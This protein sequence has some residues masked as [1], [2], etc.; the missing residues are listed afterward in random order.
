MRTCGP[1]VDVQPVELIGKGIGV[2]VA[3]GRAHVVTA[4]PLPSPSTRI[5]SD[6]VSNEQARLLAAVKLARGHMSEHVCRAHAAHDDDLRGV[7]EAHVLMLDDPHFLAEVARRIERDLLPAELALDDSFRAIATRLNASEDEYLR[8]R[9]EDMRDCCQM[10]LDGLQRGESA[11]DDPQ[12]EGPGAI[13]VSA[14]LH[15]S[16]VLRARRAGAS[17]FVS[18]SRA[19]LSHGAILLRASGIA[20]VGAV[21]FAGAEIANGT[22]L[23]V[24]GERGVVVVNPSAEQCAATSAA[25]APVE[26]VRLDTSLPPI[27][28]ISSD[29]RRVV[30]WANID[31]PADASLCFRH[32]LRGIGL[33]RTEF[34]ALSEG[35]TPGE[36]AQTRVYRQLER[37]LEGR[38]LVVRTFDLGAEKIPLGLREDRGANPALGLRGLRR[39]LHC[40]PR[41]LRV[42]LRALLRATAGAAAEVRVLLPMVTYA[43][44]LR[45]ALD[46]L[47]AA[48]DELERAGIAYNHH[49]RVG[50][51]IEVPAAALAVEEI[52]ALADFV[53]VG[54]NDLSQY[55]SATGRDVASLSHYLAPE[56]SGLYRIIDH[57]MG[58]ARRLGREDDVLVG[59]ELAS[60]PQSA[61][62]FVELGVRQLIV[63]PHAAA[64]VRTAIAALEA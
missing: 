2:G 29:G 54:T 6:E 59:G 4:P 20:S 50:A 62:K 56:R 32:R 19:L 53:A 36:E 38:P 30:L 39:Q 8:A 24:D 23:L 17:A 43:G 41:E 34:L 1:V 40:C 12:T 18:G 33:F 14:N 5:A 22:P 48:R 35:G 45:A 55:L 44:D 10:L 52:L 28:A 58:V 7:A 42:Q 61:A 63:N 13:F 26:S 57:V 25:A 51:M 15:T 27:D 9:S 11:F 3:V 47:E 64:A 37:A 49:L 16:E 46:H 31:T 60:T 21:D